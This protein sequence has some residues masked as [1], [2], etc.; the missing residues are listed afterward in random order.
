MSELKYYPVLVTQ[1]VGVS[2]NDK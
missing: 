1:I 2:K